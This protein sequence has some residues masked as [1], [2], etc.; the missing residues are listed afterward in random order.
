MA[1]LDQFLN[2]PAGQPATNGP[3]SDREGLAEF[4]ALLR[5]DDSLLAMLPCH[6]DA[7]LI[8][9]RGDAA[10][11]PIPDPYLSRLHA[12]LTWDERNGTHV[13]TDLGSANGTLLNGR[14]VRVPVRLL[15]G[16][17]LQFGMTVLRYR[18]WV[19]PACDPTASPPEV[20][21]MASTRRIQIS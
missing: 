8:V 11:I 3:I 21:A 10:S 5:P 9:G 16:N 17:A 15:D 13:V 18:R 1:G 19:A 20:D 6:S 4:A 12:R 2:R 14:R 7:E